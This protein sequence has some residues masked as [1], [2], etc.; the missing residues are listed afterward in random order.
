MTATAEAQGCCPATMHSGRN[1]ASRQAKDEGRFAV[2][3]PTLR[4]IVTCSPVMKEV[5]H[6]VRQ[7]AMVDSTVLVTGESGTG[8]EL[9]AEAIHANSP[10][11]DGPL[12][13]VD[14]TAVPESLVE[15]E[16]FGHV[17][18]SFTG[19]MANRIGRF[20]AAAGGTLFIDE[21]GDL[22]RTSQAKLLRVLEK[23]VIT[24][25]GGNTERK[26]D[27]RVV[28]ATNRPLEKMVKEGDF[29]DDLYYR[30]NI[31]RIDL[32]P[33]RERREDIALLVEHF[34][35]HFCRTYLR[36]TIQ[37]EPG[38]MNYLQTHRWPGNV[39]ELRNCVESMLVLSKGRRLTLDDVPPMVRKRP[40]LQE[41]PFDVPDNLTL[42]E[43]V[44]IVISKTLE[45]CNGNRTRAAEK[46]GI[47]VRTLQRR[48]A[49]RKGGGRLT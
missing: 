27:V 19:A 4:R 40:H 25:V 22:P 43:T 38:L 32:P 21:I 23:R 12:V 24:P 34:V 16:L 26:V 30:L 7:A 29:R 42:S 5:F 41:G 49:R 11:V 8:K 17:K 35:D 37:V 46:L 36:P 14:M 15:S 47:S 10:R 20:Q 31:V 13:I 1:G 6:Y 33:L 18:G 9:V 2:D 3:E 39:R 48:L 45:R 28:A 44:D